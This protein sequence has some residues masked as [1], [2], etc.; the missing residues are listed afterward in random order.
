M[1]QNSLTR[2]YTHKTALI[3]A[4]EMTLLYMQSYTDTDKMSLVWKERCYKFYKSV[5]RKVVDDMTQ[6]ETVSS[7]EEN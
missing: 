1:L 6:N 7:M 2:Y 4:K 5:Y 3:V